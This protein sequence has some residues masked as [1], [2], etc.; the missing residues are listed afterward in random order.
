MDQDGPVLRI[1]V[2]VERIGDPRAVAG[3]RQ[4]ET[5]WEALLLCTNSPLGMAEPRLR[6][7]PSPRRGE[8]VP[9]CRN[10]APSSPTWSAPVIALLMPN[11]RASGGRRQK[12]Q[13]SATSAA[14]RSPK[15]A[16]PSGPPRSRVRHFGSA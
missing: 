4:L 1:L 12:G 9:P 8:G 6:P 7:A 14:T 13:A 5:H 15:A 10:Q 2:A 16:V 11:S 3:R